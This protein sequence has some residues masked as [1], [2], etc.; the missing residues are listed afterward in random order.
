MNA[1]LDPVSSRPEAAAG[2]PPGG[3][4]SSPARRETQTADILPYVVPMFVYVSLG[5][6]E[7]YLPQV[8]SQPS[9][10]WY[11]I[12]LIL[13]GT[14]SSPGNPRSVMLQSARGATPRVLAVAY[15]PPGRRRA[16]SY[17]PSQNRPF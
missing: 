4:V 13:R 9:T 7:G 11:P 15:A 17:F 6:I 16:S 2:D 1:N 3:E 10:T 5:G 14:T 12:A 8:D